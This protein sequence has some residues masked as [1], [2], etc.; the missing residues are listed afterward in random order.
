MGFSQEALALL[1]LKLLEYKQAVMIATITTL[2]NT[3]LTGLLDK[4][5]C[6]N[7]S[8]YT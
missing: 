2:A 5:Y 3:Y 7:T 8:I 6:L 1:A 4:C